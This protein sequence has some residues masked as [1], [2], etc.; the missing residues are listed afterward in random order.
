MD[1]AQLTMDN[2]LPISFAELKVD[3]FSV[4]QADTSALLPTLASTCSARRDST[5]DV[6]FISILL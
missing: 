4:R 6:S 5:N 3:N 2:F 1:N